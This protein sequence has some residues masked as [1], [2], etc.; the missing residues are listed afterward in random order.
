M[1]SKQMINGKFNRVNRLHFR[2]NGKPKAFN[3]LIKTLKRLQQFS[4]RQA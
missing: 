3:G 2:L 4:R 1:D